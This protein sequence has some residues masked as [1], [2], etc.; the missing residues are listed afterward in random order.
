MPLLTEVLGDPEAIR[1]TARWAGTTSTS[2]RDGR[3]DVHRSGGESSGGWSGDAGDNFRE[4]ASRAATAIGDLA[5]SLNGTRDALDTHAGDLDSVKAEMARARG[6]ATAAGL[7]TTPTEILE[8]GPAPAA[9]T[10]LPAGRA[11]TPQEQQAH[12]AGTEAQAV[13]AAQVRAYQEA[14]QIVDAARQKEEDSQGLLQKFLGEQVE[15]SPFAL[16]DM[17]GG[18]AAL[19]INRTSEF[20]RIAQEFGNEATRR[21]G[22]ARSGGLL[23]SLR[24]TIAKEYNIYKQNQALA[25]ATPTAWSRGL[26][27]LPGGAKTFFTSNL[28][29]T[30]PFLRRVP[31]VGTL[32]T[33]AGIV[34]D[35][36]QGKGWIKSSVSGVSSLAAGAAVGAAIGGPVGLVAGAVVGAGVGFVVDEWG[37]DIAEGVDDAYGW[38]GGKVSGLF[39]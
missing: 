29:Q 31:V 15:K 19:T 8:P 6:I 4:L 13:H 2:V 18:L 1:E 23:N 34:N 28:A 22:L 12:A 38:V 35:G 33:G 25:K 5:D 7:Q 21:A 3:D 11:P 27:R 37:D 36:L 17:A 24:H 39:S 14:S 30:T 20:R 9:P 10:P 16:T 32:I 26:D